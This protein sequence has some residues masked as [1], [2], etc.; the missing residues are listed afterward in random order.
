MSKNEKSTKNWAKLWDEY[1]TALEKWR[2]SFQS[3]Q[4]ASN[5]VQTTY[6]EVME[7]GLHESSQSNMNQF[8]DSW[9]NAM[10]QSGLN[11]FKQFGE[12][13]QKSMDQSGMGQLKT[14]GEMMAKFAETWEK[15]W[16]K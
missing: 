11:A 2:T 13:W 3:L 12:N 9:K 6:N 5:D 14:Y 8:L 10:N 1:T 15:M 7:K 16:R 4:K